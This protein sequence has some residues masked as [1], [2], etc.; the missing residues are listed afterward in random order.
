VYQKD[1]WP[2]GQ[3]TGMVGVLKYCRNCTSTERHTSIYIG[4]EM[5][6]SM[7]VLWGMTASLSEGEAGVICYVE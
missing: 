3:R 2:T 6:L 5:G 1:K 4:S 7:H